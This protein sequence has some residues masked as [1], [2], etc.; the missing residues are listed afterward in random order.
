MK[1]VISFPR[2]TSS[3]GLAQLDLSERL[4]LW[5]FRAMAQHHRCACPI[6]GEIRKVYGRYQIDDVVGS[7]D[8]MIETF[9][10][11]AHTAIEIHSPNCPCVSESEKFL[12]QAMAAAQSSD[13]NG[14]RRAFERWLPELAADWIVG[15]AC[16][17]ARAFD[18]AGITLPRRNVELSDMPDTKATLSFANASRALH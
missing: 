9:A 10:S 7:L 4:F 12:L 17:I 8:T 13:L 15:P 11:N 16:A 14:A 1:N 6:N 5:G 18:T 2:E 3:D